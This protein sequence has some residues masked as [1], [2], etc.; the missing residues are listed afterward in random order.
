M[1]P[2]ATGYSVLRNENIAHNIM[3]ATASYGGCTATCIGRVA[4]KE[5][6]AQ[7]LQRGLMAVAKKMALRG[8]QKLIPIGGWVS[9]A[10]SGYSV[11]ECFVV[12]ADCEGK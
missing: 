10:Y 7:T 6:G 3:T 4:L 5:I 9:T 8:A 12:C 11:I 2:S 1:S